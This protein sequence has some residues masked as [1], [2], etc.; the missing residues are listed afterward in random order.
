MGVIR[1]NFYGIFGMVVCVVD[2]VMIECGGS[3]FFFFFLF[4]LDYIMVC[5][6]LGI[7]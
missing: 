1:K 5:C 3:G 6:V 2:L 4:M 7:N